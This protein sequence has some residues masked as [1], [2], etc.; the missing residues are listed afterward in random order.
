MMKPI[1]PADNFWKQMLEELNNTTE[2]EWSQFIEEYEKECKPMENVV[3]LC[4]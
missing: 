4:G 1:P 3:E 2:E